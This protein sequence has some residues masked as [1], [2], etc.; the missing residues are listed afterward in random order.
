MPLDVVRLLDSD[1]FALSTG[2]EFKASVALWCKSWNQVPAA[3]IPS[4]ERVLARLV[5]V[6]LAEWKTI[7]EMVLKDWVLC[8]DG[9]L[10]HGVVAEKA[11]EAWI[12]RIG[13]RKRSAQG[14]A[15]RYGHTFDEAPFEA[16]LRAA[17]E[18]L[19]VLNGETP[20]AEEMKPV[21]VGGSQTPPSK[22]N[23]DLLEGLE[24][25]PKGQGTEGTEKGTD[26]VK[27][28]SFTAS[29]ELLIDDPDAV[30]WK[31]AKQILTKHGGMT[32]AAAG[33][34]FGRVLSTNG[35]SA[36]DMMAALGMAVANQTQDPKSYLTKAAQGIKGRKASGGGEKRQS[37]V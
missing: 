2:D 1:L 35:I 15:K 21:L 20:P 26:S 14:N 34:F 30:A 27:E 16:A 5:G 17:N 13:H 10:Y 3:S 8:D 25:A 19:K 28:E 6:S 23:F 32:P 31:L 37:Y 24:N 4:D 36:K 33:S 12:E 22:E 29:G 7:A 11:L 18:R 9:R